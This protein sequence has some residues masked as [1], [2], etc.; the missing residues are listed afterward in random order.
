MKACAHRGRSASCAAVSPARRTADVFACGLL[1]TLLLCG[2]GCSSF[3]RD[4]QAAAA[5]GGG[6]SFQG[7]WEGRWT[8][9][10]GH[11]GGK[12]R[13][14]LS[15]LALPSAG[16]VAG[17]AGSAVA[18]ASPLMLR[19]DTAPSTAP[20]EEYQARFEATYWGIFHA[21]YN[22]TLS[23]PE[24]AGALHLSGRKNLGWLEGGVYEYDATVTPHRF[25]ATY[26]SKKDQGTF[27]M[28]RPG[29]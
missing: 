23:G 26:R 6:Q 14:I 27:S 21:H 13:C 25:D 16:A 18:S 20:V 12:L 15:R 1:L 28:T 22:T 10:R 4:W 8:S 19:A 3:G 5:Q 17:T 7:A 29:S 9:N 24:T 2:T 11:G